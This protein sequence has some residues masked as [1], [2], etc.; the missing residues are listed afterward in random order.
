MHNI[1][2]KFIFKQNCS[3]IISIMEISNNNEKELKEQLIE[4]IAKDPSNEDNYIELSKIYLGEQNFEEALGVYE[5]L[6]KINPFNSQALIN[7]G[8]LYFY[9]KNINK[10]IDYYT[11]ATELESKSFSV[12]MNLGNAYAEL[13][14]F[15]K[16]M[17]NYSKALELENNSAAFI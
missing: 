16:A 14:D 1:F 7:A 4:K 13:N 15:D 11:R 10:S 17:K 8:S 6:L 9:F 12:Y 5:A 2:T 3:N